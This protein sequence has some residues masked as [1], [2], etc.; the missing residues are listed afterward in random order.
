M[1]KDKIVPGNKY[2]NLLFLKMR[3][4]TSYKIKWQLENK[5]K[6]QLEKQRLT[7]KIITRKE[8]QSLF[9]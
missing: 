1:V 8:A 4:I 9:F 3:N 5:I 7:A 2:R 6:W